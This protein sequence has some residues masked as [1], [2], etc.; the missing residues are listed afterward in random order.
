MV[1]NEVVSSSAA[2]VLIGDNLP[3]IYVDNKG[4]LL[5]GSRPSNQHPLDLIER[6]LILP[7]VIALGS[8]R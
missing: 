2:S 7:P 6:H 1:S 8:A 3:L 5:G 4:R